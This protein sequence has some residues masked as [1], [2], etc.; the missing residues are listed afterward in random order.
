MAKN[1]PPKKIT[2]EMKVNIEADIKEK[3]LKD[4]ESQKDLALRHNVSQTT[5][6]NMVWVVLREMENENRVRQELASKMTNSEE[7]VAKYGIPKEYQ[8]I[9]K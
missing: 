2:P 3:Y 6:S 4:L 1:I 7:A 8:L 9:K 5:I